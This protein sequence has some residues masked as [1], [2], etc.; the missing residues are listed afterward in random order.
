MI[1]SVMNNER[2]MYLG[3]KKVFFNQHFTKLK[4]EY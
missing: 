2:T 3:E 4:M 1:F